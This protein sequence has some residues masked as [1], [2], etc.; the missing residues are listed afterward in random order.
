[1]GS[2]KR[3]IARRGDD[4][5]WS[6][7]RRPRPRSSEARAATI[8]CSDS[9]TTA[10]RTHRSSPPGAVNQSLDKAD[11]IEGGAG[12]DVL[13]GLGGSD[14]LLGG[15][16]NDI[17]VGGTEQFAGAEQ[18]HRCSAA[19][20]T[21]SRCGAGGDGSEA[22][23]GGRGDADAL[24]FG[25]IDRDAS[26]IPI[27]S[28][29]TK[30]HAKTGIPTADVT[31]QGGWC[32]LE[33]VEDPDAGYQ[34]LVRFIVRSTG[35]LAAHRPDARRRAGLL[36][37]RPRRPDH[38]RRSHRGG[39]RVRRRRS[40]RG[41][42]STRRS[43]RSSARRPPPAQRFAGG[44][45]TSLNASAAFLRAVKHARRKPVT[46]RRPAHPVD[47]LAH[48]IRAPAPAIV[49]DDYRGRAFHDHGMC[50]RKPEVGRVT[51]R[52]SDE[53]RTLAESAVRH[54]LRTANRATA[55]SP[56][57][58]DQVRLAA[59]PPPAS[60]SPCTSSA[61]NAASSRAATPRSRTLAA[62]R[63]FRDS[64]QGEEPDSTSH[65]GFY[66]HFL[67][68]QTGRRTWNC[69]LSMIDT[70]ILIAGVLTAGTYFSAPDDD[71][72]EIRELARFL[73]ERVDWRWAT[74]GGRV[75]AMGWKPGPG[76]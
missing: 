42:R 56:T 46:R 44:V 31:H 52:L 50:S 69:E 54:F 15:P 32:E 64:P 33:R 25:N 48:V 14:V 24:I 30:R 55:S 71:E 63:F 28:P 12:D 58:R 16:G 60:G 9:T 10:K 11:V 35:N 76:S 45:R 22:F 21:T 7:P 26:N 8:S 2:T 59:S 27:I 73:Y 67:D 62:L 68:L 17:L 57:A 37:E 34:F 40:R 6:V 43:G 3:Q 36:H 61:W 72:R 5:C 13:V 39:S 41:R 1:M 23:L 18:R 75:V 20:A 47:G 19:M 53:L 65:R 70:A 4:A 49:T 66:Y 29:T 74:N 38:L 51:V